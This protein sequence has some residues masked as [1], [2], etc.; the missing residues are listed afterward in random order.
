[1]PGPG[2][3]K[4]REPRLTGAGF[5]VGK[6]CILVINNSKK[7]PK[8]PVFRQ[9]NR[10]W[11]PGPGEQGMVTGAGEPGPGAKKAG[12][13]R[14]TGAGPQSDTADNKHNIFLKL[15]GK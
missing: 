3:E 4:A 14:W 6:W 7:F 12:E 13:P 15:I 1:M 8:S 2:A 5:P 11:G 10:G 9:L